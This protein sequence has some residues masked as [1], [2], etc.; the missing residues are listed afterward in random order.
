M[1]AA[2]RLF[3]TPS[4]VPG[5][6]VSDKIDMELSYNHFALGKSK[7]KTISGINTSGN[8]SYI[9]HNITLGMRLAL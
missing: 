4:L 1:K 6:K 9:V 2:K 8:R 3:N 5:H 7:A